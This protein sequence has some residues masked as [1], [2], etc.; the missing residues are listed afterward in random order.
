MGWRIQSPA[1]L[2]WVGE[3][4][5]PQN[6]NGLEN[7]IP[8]KTQMGWKIQFPAKLK[9]NTVTYMQYSHIHA[10]QSHTCNTGTYMQ[11]RHIHA[12]Q[13]H[14][15]NKGTYRH[16]QAHTVTYR[17]IQAHTVTY[18]RTRKVALPSV[19]LPNDIRMHL[20]FPVRPLVPIKS[21]T[22]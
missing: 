4:N 18:R 2:K 14:T 3:S 19:R 10:I 8:S 20:S 9:Y 1:K 7:P 5:P 13:A 22:L 12:I 16:I 21:A 6:S 11:Y 15:F 17:H